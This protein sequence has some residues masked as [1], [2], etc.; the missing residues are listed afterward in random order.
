MT[1]AMAVFALLGALDRGLIMVPWIPVPP[2][3]LRILLEVVWVPW[4]VV[5]A[6]QGRM[7]ARSRPDP[8]V[9]YAAALRE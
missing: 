3:L 4:A 8:L 9:R 1:T 5:A 2:S 7:L 6:V